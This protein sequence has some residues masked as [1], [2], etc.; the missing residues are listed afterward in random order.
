LAPLSQRGP[1][2]EV[3]HRLIVACLDDLSYPG[4]AEP[5]CLGD[6]SSADSFGPGSMDVRVPG[7]DHGFELRTQLASLAPR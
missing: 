4:V 5:G 6:G 1:W 3:S 7:D 2:P